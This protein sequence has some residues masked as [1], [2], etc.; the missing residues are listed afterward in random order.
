[1]DQQLELLKDAG[2]PKPQ[3]LRGKNIKLE[4]GTGEVWTKIISVS[5]IAND[6]G[7]P[8][9]GVAPAL[10]RGDTIISVQ[11]RE[12]GRLFFRYKYTSNGVESSD[13][14]PCKLTFI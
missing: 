11:V 10:F 8:E 14:S 12:G 4:V 2:L 9:L 5:T 1:M 13:L 7:Y 6:D 3:D